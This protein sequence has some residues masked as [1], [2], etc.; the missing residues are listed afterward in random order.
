MSN[1][2]ST[3]LAELLAPES[4]RLDAV[5]TDKLD[6]VRQC[7]DA[8]LTAGAVGAEYV[9]AMIE[10]EER[11][12]TYI[13]E[14]VAMPHGTV[15]GKDMVKQSAIVFLRFPDGVDWDGER[16]DVAVGIAAQGDGH[17][18]VLTQLA[19]ILIDAEKAA[20]LRGVTSADEV[21]RLLAPEG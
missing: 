17:V 16:V 8:L 5:A 10:R 1:A 19:L 4:I 18:A 6:A 20:A 15:A 2:A 7:G 12:T 3:P 14:G 21:Y 13:G 9:D 11:L